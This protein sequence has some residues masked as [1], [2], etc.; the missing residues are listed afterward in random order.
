MKILA[1]QLNTPIY[2]AQGNVARQSSQSGEYTNTQSFG[3]NI[4]LKTV[5]NYAETA[6][7]WLGEKTTP[8]NRF[9]IG[10]FA[11][12]TQPW[13]DLFNKDVDEETRKASCLRTMAKIIVGTTTGIFTRMGCISLMKHFTMTD[14]EL[15]GKPRKFYHDWLV[16]SEKYVSKEQ[17][18][19]AKTLLKNHR[20]TIGTMVAIGVMMATDPPLT[21]LMTNFFNKKHKETMTRDAAKK[22]AALKGGN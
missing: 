20:N 1:N 10:A 6:F 22:E 18:A 14:Q 21:K 12:V 7:N 13:I 5:G 11:F 2:K 19:Q 15:A 16:P 9:V 3:N 8:F 17:F 4:K